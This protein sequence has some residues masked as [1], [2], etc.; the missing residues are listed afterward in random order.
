[1]RKP[2]VEFR[3]TKED[4]IGLATVDPATECQAR[5][6]IVM[7]KTKSSPITPKLP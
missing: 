7:A 5:H 4:L 6:D 1:V 3:A 2:P